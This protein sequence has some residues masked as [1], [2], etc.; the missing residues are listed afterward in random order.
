M[1]RIETIEDPDVDLRELNELLWQASDEHVWPDFVDTVSNEQAIE[2]WKIIE[3][4]RRKN[5]HPEWK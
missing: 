2:C 4:L 5:E 3:Y 1:I